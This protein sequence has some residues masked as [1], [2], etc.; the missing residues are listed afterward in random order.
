MKKTDKKLYATLDVLIKTLIQIQ[1]EMKKDIKANETYTY[2]SFCNLN[3][4]N[5]SRMDF[6]KDV[7]AKMEIWALSQGYEKEL[8]STW[9]E[10]KITNV[11]PNATK[12]T[13]K[14]FK[15]LAD[16]TTD[17]TIHKLVNSILLNNNK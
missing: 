1:D 7:K 11:N 6:S 16:N 14:I 17:K 12:I 8:T 3:V 10:I 2:N 4:V 9:Q 5:K 15:T 13:N